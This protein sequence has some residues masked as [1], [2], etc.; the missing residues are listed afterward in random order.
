MLFHFEIQS[1]DG[2]DEGRVGECVQDDQ[3]DDQA[4]LASATD[5][6]VTESLGWR[7][8]VVVTEIA[9]GRFLGE[10]SSD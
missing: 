10:V 9:T 7:D 4:A 3:P 8:T 6:F 5:W 1:K 2:H